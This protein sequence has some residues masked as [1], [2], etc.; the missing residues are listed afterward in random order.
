M[1]SR[2]SASFSTK[3]TTTIDEVILGLD[4]K[5]IVGPIVSVWRHQRQY[6]G[7]AYS[8]RGPYK[9]TT[10]FLRSE[11]SFAQ[12]SLECFGKTS[13]VAAGDI[14]IAIDA[15]QQLGQL[16][17]SCPFSNRRADDGKF[18]LEHPDLR[19]D[20]I[21][22]DLKTCKVTG[23]ID[24][25]SASIIPQWQTSVFP[26]FLQRVDVEVE[27]DLTRWPY[28]TWP[29]TEQVERLG[30]YRDTCVRS[31]LQSV[32]ESSPSR[33]PEDALYDRYCFLLSQSWSFP[34]NI[35]HQ[36]RNFRRSGIFD[37]R[38]YQD[39]DEPLQELST[40]TDPELI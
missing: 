16:L 13:S 24:W 3:A 35:M 15:C 14:S 18:V 23:I 19:G 4:S 32:A 25:E 26:R 36:V 37:Y 33:H 12:C 5:Y 29:H 22:V 17:D 11:T 39:S 38:Q 1:S 40:C 21:L 8:D 20:N 7:T 30:Q 9:S 34:E 27:P 6:Q 31:R 10:E 28:S 2:T